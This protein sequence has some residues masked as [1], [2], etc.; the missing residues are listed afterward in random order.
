MRQNI[1]VRCMYTFCSTFFN[2]QR[3][4]L[5]SLIARSPLQVLST[6]SWLAFIIDMHRQI[7]SH[8]YIKYSFLPKDWQTP[9]DEFYEY[10]LARFNLSKIFYSKHR[11]GLIFIVFYYQALLCLLFGFPLHFYFPYPFRAAIHFLA[12]IFDII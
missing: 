9:G 3:I 8:P 4:N 12:K 7:H 2:D 10:K 5:F 1:K 6:L 11:M